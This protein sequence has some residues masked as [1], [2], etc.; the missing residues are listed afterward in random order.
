MFRKS[1]G[2]DDIPDL[3]FLGH[4]E[5]FVR[6]EIT[7]IMPDIVV[8]DFFSRVGCIVADELN[9]PS[10]VN[11]PA[12]YEFMLNFGMTGTLNYK[13]AKVCCGQ[14]CFEE[15]CIFCFGR[16]ISKANQ[17]L[18]DQE[19]YFKSFNQRPMLFNSFWGYD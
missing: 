2:L 4:W 1:K 16:L 9:I 10:V 17:P 12:L 7:K 14:I 18:R 13:K 5:K 6:K 19:K 11:A 8:C 15:K 3:V